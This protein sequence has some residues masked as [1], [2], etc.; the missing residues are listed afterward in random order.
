MLRV[1]RSQA[2][3]HRG[4]DLLQRRAALNEI[5]VPGLPAH[6]DDAVKDVAAICVIPE[7]EEHAAATD[8][9]HR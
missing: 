3:F 4:V 2:A 7:E 5:T 9:P 8:A 6:T 1:E